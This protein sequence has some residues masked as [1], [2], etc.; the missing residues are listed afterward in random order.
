MPPPK[1]RKAWAL[2]AYLVCS[3]V[4]PSRE[5]LATLLFSDADDPLGAL[6][7]N[8]AEL[9][10]LLGSADVVTGE[11]ITLRFPPGTF[12][13]VRAVTSGTWK[14]GVEVDG[15]GKDLL[16][17]MSF[18]SSPSFEAWLLTERRHLIASA[19]NVLREAA[20][21]RLASGDAERAVDLS[22]R[23][24]AIDPLDE[25]FQSIFIRSLAAAG[26]RVAAMK[27]FEDTRKLF[28][29]ELGTE[30]SVT[31][32]SA[33]DDVQPGSSTSSP[34]TGRAAARAQLDA[35]QAAMAAGAVAAGFECLRR[36]VYESHSAADLELKSEA[37]FALGHAFVHAARG[38]DDEGAAALHEC[39]QIAETTGNETLASST[40]RE[41]GYVEYLR[42]RYD[43]ARKL[44]E[45]ALPLAPPEE[46]V[47]TLAYLGGVL[48]DIAHYRD[49]EERLTEALGTARQLGVP[50]LVVMATSWL[51]RLYLLLGDDAAAHPLADESVRLCRREAMTS[52]VSWP[53][54][55][56]AELEL[57][58]GNVDV[59]ADLFEHA[60][61]L[62]C[63]L[64]DP[65]WTGLSGRGLGLVSAARGHVAAGVRTIEEARIQAVRLPDCYLW[66][67]AYALD[68]MCE[69]AVSNA[70]P[71]ARGWVSDL[72]SLAARTGMREMVAR[73]YLFRHRL[74]DP[75][76]FEAIKLFTEEIENPALRELVV[77]ATA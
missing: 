4:P 19:A 36:A 29:K 73:A 64:G 37:L 11:P 8:L 34:A 23:L 15:L 51:S 17:G 46:R 68:A 57:R 55:F 75:E 63:Q 70:L 26:D 60:Y 69:L 56:L 76:A 5:R 31:L 35:G 40:Y 67:E 7:W 62:G 24:V 20:L 44:L 28:L 2:L 72:E 6:R 48:T 33:L 61:A 49:A 1:G 42:A 14:E 74:G 3:E 39:L 52:F 53:E 41:L 65:C 9:R 38:R 43:R 27:Q 47:M 13:D 71:E 18:S 10:R 77:A 50:R 25:S 58:S 59:A 66:I 45:L 30:P 32:R 12:V 21:A 16:E 54:S 22:Q